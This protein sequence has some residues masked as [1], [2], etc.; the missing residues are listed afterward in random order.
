MSKLLKEVKSNPHF[1]L[2]GNGKIRCILTN[3]DIMPDLESFH[4]YLEVKILKKI[5][6]MIYKFLF[7]QIILKLFIHSLL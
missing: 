4:K 5:L 6:I 3:H 2:L 1:E 7:H